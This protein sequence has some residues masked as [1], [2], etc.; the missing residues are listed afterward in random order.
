[1]V[2]WNGDFSMRKRKFI[3]SRVEHTKLTLSMSLSMKSETTSFIRH[4]IIAKISSNT[5]TSTG[6][7]KKTKF[8]NN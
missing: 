8:K 1:M 7:S 3:I 5:I 6:P 4:T 2:L